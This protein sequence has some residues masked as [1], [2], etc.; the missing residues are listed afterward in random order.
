MIFIK[1][2]RKRSIEAKENVTFSFSFFLSIRK[3][4]QIQKQNTV[5]KRKDW[6]KKRIMN[7]RYIKSELLCILWNSYSLLGHFPSLNPYC[8]LCSMEKLIMTPATKV[9][10]STESNVVACM[11]TTIG[12]TPFPPACFFFLFFLFSLTKFFLFWD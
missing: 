8:E 6:R 9:E 7:R 4:I 12:H 11:A 5:K 3:E 2:R 10:K 1:E